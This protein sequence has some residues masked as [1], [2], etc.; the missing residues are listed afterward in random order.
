MCLGAKRLQFIALRPDRLDMVG[1]V[2]GL[3]A[4]PVHRGCRK[5]D[6]QRVR[7]NDLVIE[8]GARNHRK[9]IRVPLEVGFIGAKPVN[10]GNQG[11]EIV[12]RLVR[13]DHGDRCPGGACDDRIDHPGDHRQRGAG[14]GGAHVG[15][16]E[17]RF[18]RV[19][20]Q[21]LDSVQHHRRGRID[22]VLGAD[23]GQRVESA[24]AHGNT[25]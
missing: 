18:D 4:H 10:I 14:V 7:R 6:I 16:R 25:F 23:S 20:L 19:Q 15:N 2:A 9:D 3:G 11:V 12:T 21:L 24:A 13:I 22:D 8:S 5:A 1:Y 17:S